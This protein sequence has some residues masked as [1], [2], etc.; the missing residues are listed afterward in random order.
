MCCAQIA[1]ARRRTSPSSRRKMRERSSVLLPITCEMMEASVAVL[2]P[3]CPA[4]PEAWPMPKSGTVTS[5]SATAR[6]ACICMG[7]SCGDGGK[8]TDLTS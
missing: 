4:M 3:L 5:C 7:M 8:S 2:A 6:A 1:Q